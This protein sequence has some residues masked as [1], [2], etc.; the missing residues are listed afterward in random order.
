M[1]VCVHQIIAKEASLKIDL[2]DVILTFSNSSMVMNSLVYT[3]N[4]CHKEF[5]VVVVDARPAM[6]G[7][8]F[9]KELMKNGIPCTYIYINAIS[10]ILHEVTKVSHIISHLILII[11]M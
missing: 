10:Y 1:K 3:W 11:S 5:R 4:H 9:M 7:R 8:D 6:E 2:G